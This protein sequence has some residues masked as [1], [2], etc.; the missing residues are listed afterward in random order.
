MWVSFVRLAVASDHAS[1]QLIGGARRKL[2]G[3]AGHPLL[4]QDEND[5]M[6][7]IESSSGDSEH[8]PNAQRVARY[9]YSGGG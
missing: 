8:K 7:L 1:G 3:G 6:Q 9:N 2:Y 4:L 5:L